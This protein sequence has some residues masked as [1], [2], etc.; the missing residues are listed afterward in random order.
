MVL[1]IIIA[2]IASFHQ[3]FTKQEKARYVPPAAETNRIRQRLLSSFR[4]KFSLPSI[5]PS[6]FR[7]S[8][9]R[10]T[11]LSGSFSWSSKDC[12]VP[13]D[14]VYVSHGV[15]ISPEAKEAGNGHGDQDTYGNSFQVHNPWVRKSSVPPGE[16]HLNRGPPG[17][18]TLW[19]GGSP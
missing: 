17:S 7:V 2:C 6:T 15:G 3:L 13:L 18:M 4:S 11:Q 16:S 10:K 14:N 19:N 1:A 8:F 12:I 9:A 5:I